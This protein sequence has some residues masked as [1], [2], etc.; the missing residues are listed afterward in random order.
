MCESEN[1]CVCERMH[2]EYMYVCKCVHVCKLKYPGPEYSNRSAH[3]VGN[4]YFFKL[5][6]TKLNNQKKNY[7]QTKNN[8]KQIII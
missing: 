2:R 7:I 5:F 3:C 8:N 6:K 1:V 4:Y